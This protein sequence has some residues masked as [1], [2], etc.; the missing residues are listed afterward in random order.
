ML[1]KNVNDNAGNRFTAVSLR[2]FASMLAPQETRN[3]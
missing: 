2:F 3:C 1:A